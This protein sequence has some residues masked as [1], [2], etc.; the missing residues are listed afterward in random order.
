[1]FQGFSFLCSDLSDF[2]PFSIAKSILIWYNCL[3]VRIMNS[4]IQCTYTV[5]NFRLKDDTVV[6]HDIHKE[7]FEFLVFMLVIRIRK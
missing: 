1:M 3:E 6:L 2:F 5:E 7:P 4:K